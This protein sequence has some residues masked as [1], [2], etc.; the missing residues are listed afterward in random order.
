MGNNARMDERKKGIRKDLLKTKAD[1]EK[2]GTEPAA[3]SVTFV[4]IS[5]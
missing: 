3:N 4:Q 5:T 1:V 2:E